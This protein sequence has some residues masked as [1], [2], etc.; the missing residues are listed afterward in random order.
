MGWAESPLETLLIC[1]G[2]R[3]DYSLNKGSQLIA[4]T[5]LG[6]MQ[7]KMWC[8]LITVRQRMARVN[9]KEEHQVLMKSFI[10]KRHCG[11]PAVEC[12]GVVCK[13]GWGFKESKEGTVVVL[14][15]SF[16][17]F[18]LLWGSAL[19][20]TRLD[21]SA[22]HPAHRINTG[23]A[24]PLFVGSSHQHWSG[25]VKLLCLGTARLPAR[26]RADLCWLMV[27]PTAY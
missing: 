11:L 19:T 13:Q 16:Q 9:W 15:I 2:A 8:P 18:I 20:T 25:A 5:L 23:S 26:S 14:Y 3:E 22:I 21:S 17:G 24:L 6:W 27:G 1:C 4:C 7:A 12:C 10:E